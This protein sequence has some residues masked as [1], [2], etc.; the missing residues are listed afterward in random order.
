MLN[1]LKSATYIHLNHQTKYQLQVQTW[2][3]YK[4]YTYNIQKTFCYHLPCFFNLD[5]VHIENCSIVRIRLVKH[6]YNFTLFKTHTC[7]LCPK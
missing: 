7:H 4:E 3:S 6:I 2:V 1:Y 5:H